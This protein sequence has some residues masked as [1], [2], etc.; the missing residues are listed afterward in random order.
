MRIKHHSIFK[1]K[2]KSL[3]WEFLRNQ[4]DEA[5]YYLPNRLQDY[6]KKYDSE[7]PSV[8]AFEII[9]DINSNKVTKVFSIG[10][11]I[12]ALEY[13]IKKFSNIFVL[14]SDFNNSILRLKEF[15]LFD[16]VVVFNILKQNLPIDESWYVIMPRIDTEFSDEQLMNIFHKQYECGVNNI[17]FIPAE[18]LSIKTIITELKIFLYAVIRGEKRVFCGYARSLSTFKKLWA[19]FFFVRKY[20]KTKSRHLIFLSRVNNND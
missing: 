1:S 12:A 16:E 8:E 19:P 2:I 4:K 17:C 7:E 20:V 10:S 6:L 3:D 18:Y 11:G 9:N 13:Q 15:N 14:I 5:A